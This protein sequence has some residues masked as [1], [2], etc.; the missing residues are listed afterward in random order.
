M[1]TFVERVF[2]HV[3]YVTQS[4]V[5]VVVMLMLQNGCCCVYVYVY[6]YVTLYL[7][8]NSA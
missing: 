1:P 3:A 7:V 6:E 8:P 5:L 2:W 4:K